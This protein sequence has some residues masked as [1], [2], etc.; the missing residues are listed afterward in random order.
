VRGAGSRASALEFDIAGGRGREHDQRL[1][2]LLFAFAAGCPDA[3]SP[4][5]QDAPDVVVIFAA[6]DVV[7]CLRLA[8]LQLGQAIAVKETISGFEPT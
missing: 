3:G 5:T 1:D 4:G 7:R 6:K 8:T 2:S